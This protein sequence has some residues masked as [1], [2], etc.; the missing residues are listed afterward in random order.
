M[1]ERAVAVI[2]PGRMGRG[3]AQIL[4]TEGHDVWVLD[5]KDRPPEGVTETFEAVE[6]TV[7]QNLDVLARCGSF[8]GEP[9]AVL[10]R[11][12]CTR[13]VE[14]VAEADWVF[15]ALPEDPAVKQAGLEQISPFLAPEAIVATTTSAISL[16]V[17]VD[18]V[19]APERLLITHW[20]NPAFIVPLVEVAQT[21]D[22]APSVVDQTV[23]FLENVGKVPVVCQD[24]PGFIG[25]RIQAAAMNEA[26]RAWEDGVASAAEIDKALRYGVGL[27]M[28][29][30][31]LLE[32]V[33]LGGVD[34]LHHV[35]EYLSEELGTRFENPESVRQ[36]IERNE[37]GPRTGQGYYDWDDRDASERWAE[38]YDELLALAMRLGVG[39]QD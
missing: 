6:T 1:T 32:F 11:V 19:P 2:G 38:A 21:E 20:L 30:F 16:D 39:P 5:L 10:D 4:A 23:T 17:L 12:T 37:V 15:E 7:R 34:I 8:D 25:S 29:V 26:V 36:K 13:S 31:G 3:I 14:A 9:D 33:D 27:R 35:N 24:S 18:A 22:T 28:A